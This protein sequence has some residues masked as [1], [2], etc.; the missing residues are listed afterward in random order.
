MSARSMRFLHKIGDL[1]PGVNLKRKIMADENNFEPTHT[2]T[3]RYR[4]P[5][6]LRKELLQIGFQDDDIKI[7]VSLM[8]D[9][10]IDSG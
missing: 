5:A 10:S 7:R 1:I 4:D 8:E 3:Q 6:V 2:F 9:N